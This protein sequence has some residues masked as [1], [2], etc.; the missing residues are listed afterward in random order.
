MEIC[1]HLKIMVRLAIYIYIYILFFFYD[2]AKRK[3]GLKEKG[4]EAFTGGSSLICVKLT[5][6]LVVVNLR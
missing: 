5:S 1:G 6:V 2:R 4:L 3:K